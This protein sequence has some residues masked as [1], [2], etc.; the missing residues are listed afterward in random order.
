MGTILY[1]NEPKN[2]TKELLNLINNFSKV[3]GFKTI[4]NKSIIFIYSKDKKAKK[5]IREMSPF[6]IFTNNITYLAVTL[7][8]KKNVL[9]EKN[10]KTLKKEIKDLRR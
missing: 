8:K 7:T 10:F 3:A 4:S 6:T 5:E 2:S 9:Y 1:F